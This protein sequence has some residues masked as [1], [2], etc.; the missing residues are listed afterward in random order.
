MT[1]KRDLQPVF[2]RLRR[3]LKAHTK[4][5][6]VESDTADDYS[7]NAG[8]SETYKRVLYVGGVQV[9][10]NYV[11]YHLMPVYMFPELLQDMSPALRKRMQGKSCFNFTRIDETLFAELDELTQRGLARAREMRLGKSRL[12]D[13]YDHQSR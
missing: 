8:Y 4:R 12:P 13:A 9:K 11:S 7:V 10:K 2:E 1:V 3:I 6:T 5:L